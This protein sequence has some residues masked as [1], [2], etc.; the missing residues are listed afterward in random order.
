[1]LDILAKLEEIRRLLKER[2]EP[3]GGAGQGQDPTRVP[4]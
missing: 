4:H 2:Q 3:G 1:M